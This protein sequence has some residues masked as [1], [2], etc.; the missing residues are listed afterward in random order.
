MKSYC[1]LI[2]P[3]LLANSINSQEIPFE[4]YQYIEEIIEQNQKDSDD[5]INIE[6]V[7]S[8][9]EN[10]IINPINLNTCNE[11]DL[12][13]LFMLN[14]FQIKSLL[15]YRKQTGQIVS[16]KELFYIY[17]F[18]DVTVKLISPFV[19]INQQN[20]TKNKSK[21]TQKYHHE[22]LLRAT[23]SSTT[24]DTYIGNKQK[25]YARYK[26]D[27]KDFKFAII[28]EKDPGEEFFS[29]SNKNG[30]DS[31]TGF[32]SYSPKKI[33][34]NIVVGDYRVLAGQG[35]LYWM[36]YSTGTTSS[37][38]SIL[39]RGQGCSGNTSADERNFLRGVAVDSKIGNFDVNI[40][41]SKKYIDVTLDT[42]LDEAI[43]RTIRTDGLHRT[44]TEISYEKAADELVYGGRILYSQSHLQ[45]GLNFMHT[46]FSKDIIPD[47]DP[48]KAYSFS[49]NYVTGYSV[50]YKYLSERFQIFGETA[51]SNNAW[52]NIT[53]INLLPHPDVTSTLV[54]RNYRPGYF[55]PYA[56]PISSSSSQLQEQ[57]FLYGITWNTNWKVNLSAYANIY[58][59]PWLKYR[60]DGPSSGRD[61]L[62]EGKWTL[63]SDLSMILRYKYK[64]VYKNYSENDESYLSDQLPFYK[65]QFR[66]HFNYI[67]SDKIK[68]A[69]RAEYAGSHF[70]NKSNQ[71]GYLV[72]QDIFYEAQK[73]FKIKLRYAWFDVED[74]NSRIYA[75][76]HNAR[77][78]YSMP[79]Y[80]G[81]GYKTYLLLQL[82]IKK[83]WSFWARYSFTDYFDD[84]ENAHSGLIQIFWKI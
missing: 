77:F 61:Y 36:G 81:K 9:L 50:D 32:I 67:I 8:N 51:L 20:I 26:S 14:D 75:Y 82:K 39:R 84:K 58:S 69:T 49:G 43:I 35:L 5:E 4:I 73:A 34:N 78:N 15:S 46:A 66:I 27:F 63:A 29:G 60:V 25:Y 18:T 2:L 17:G 30:F 13:Q 6:S 47:D 52:S 42:L 83:N 24:E 72:Y 11:L 37:T 71:P 19:T 55:S 1:C 53:G 48:Y 44:E 65:E 64:T 79:M 38:S 28:G 12:E 54:Y 10:L 76:E 16:L 23:Q 21:K 40:F 33:I 56:N 41:T 57:G 74:Y 7:F 45:L 3:L 22:I 59:F 62:L 80:Y 31:Y 68:M 70:E